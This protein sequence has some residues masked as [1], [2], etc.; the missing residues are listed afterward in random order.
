MPYIDPETD[1]IFSDE[2]ASQYNYINP[3]TGNPLVKIGI[4]G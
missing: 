2:E 4:M 1:E 3:R